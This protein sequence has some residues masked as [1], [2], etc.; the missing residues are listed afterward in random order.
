V[1]AAVAVAVVVVCG[2][3]WE[4]QA[5]AAAVV[6]LGFLGALADRR[7]AGRLVTAHGRHRVRGSEQEKQ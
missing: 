6:V 2:C 3:P 7:G 4:G 1:S 5:A